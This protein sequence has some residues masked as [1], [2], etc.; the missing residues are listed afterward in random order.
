[1][2]SPGPDKLA[3]RKAAQRVAAGKVRTRVHAEKGDGVGDTLAA[4][5]GS[6]IH[7]PQGGIV[8][9]FWP[10][11]SEINIVP[12]LEMLAGQGLRICLPVVVAMGKPLVFRAWQPGDDLVPGKWNIPVPADTQPE[13]TPDVLLVPLLAFD[14]QGYRLGY[15]GGFYDRTLEKLRA[16][17]PVKAI[18][19]AYRAQQVDAVEHD[20]LD[21]PLDGVL[22]EQGYFEPDRAN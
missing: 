12:L 8:S 16:H 9:G 17:G 18:G 7:W 6:R 20:S 14:R 15:G 21:Q 1:M 11:G 3:E 19:V 5:A 2:T 13:M 22:T 10:F 4:M